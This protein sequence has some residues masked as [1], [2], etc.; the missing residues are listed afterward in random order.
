[1]MV[2]I[3]GHCRKND[4]GVNF[5]C[6]TTTNSSVFKNNQTLLS[7]TI[8]LKE[9]NY[10]IFEY[11]ACKN[12]VDFNAE[13]DSPPSYVP[14]ALHENKAT[15]MSRFCRMSL[16]KVFND[17]HLKNN[18]PGKHLWE[19]SFKAKNKFKTNVG[20]IAAYELDHMVKDSGQNSICTSEGD[21][22]IPAG[23]MYLGLLSLDMTDE[24]LEIGKELLHHMQECFPHS[25]G[26][27]VQT[28]L[29]NHETI[30]FYL[31]LGFL[32]V[33]M[34]FSINTAYM[35]TEQDWLTLVLPNTND[36]QLPEKFP[37][38]V[39]SS[40][41]LMEDMEM[42][43]ENFIDLIGEK[44]DTLLARIDSYA[45]YANHN[46]NEDIDTAAIYQENRTIA[47]AHPRKPYTHAMHNYRLD[48]LR[49]SD[50]KKFERELVWAAGNGDLY[51]VYTLLF[52]EDVNPDAR[53]ESGVTALIQA[54]FG[55]NDNYGVVELLLTKRANVNIGTTKGL[56]PLMLAAF[57]GYDDI[58]NYLIQEGSYV[59]M[60]DQFGNTALDYAFRGGHNG[61]VNAL[62]KVGAKKRPETRSHVVSDSRPLKNEYSFCGNDF[63]TIAELCAQEKACLAMV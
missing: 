9:D 48:L 60:K 13:N 56:T 19:L 4:G 35:D 1:M 7:K 27:V 3:L 2:S 54:I 50:A 38:Y 16:H 42:S 57:R 46:R 24:Y 23:V 20:L 12:A 41:D 63:L 40:D 34:P 39:M 29:L 11:G 10:I 37:G 47:T 22:V 25:T 8:M 43:K 15:P 52:Q 36:S 6:D 14:K 5:M 18:H 33:A 62:V 58:V 17:D 51:R 21:Y 28:R 32:P 30:R 55:G 53:N 61:C 31:N 45:L 44:I 49:K 59:N 26:F